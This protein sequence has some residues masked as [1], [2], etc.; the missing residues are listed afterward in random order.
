M[1]AQQSTTCGV[2][3]DKNWLVTDTQPDSPFF[4]RIYQFWTEFL[5]NGA[6][7]QV[8]RWSDDQ[9]QHWS[10]THFLASRK[11]FAQNSQAFVQPN[12]AITDTYLFAGHALGDSVMA[13]H[14][15][16]RHQRGQRHLDSGANLVRRG[17]PLDQAGGGGQEHRRRPGRYPLLPAAHGG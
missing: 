2:S 8:V 3:D 12:G 7:P 5:S 11:Q 17:R 1:Y 4:G 14:P 9:G 10:S 6:S 16:Q 15:E 13:G